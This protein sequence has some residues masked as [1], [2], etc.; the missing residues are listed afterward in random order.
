MQA[1]ATSTDGGYGTTRGTSVWQGPARW[2]LA[3][4]NYMDVVLSDGDG[5]GYGGEARQVDGEKCAHSG[6]GLYR[7]PMLERGVRNRRV[8]IQWGPA[9][10][11][12][13]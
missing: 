8:L 13:I 3:R 5:A 10:C 9:R 12:T 7:C 2:I 11:V 1:E 4:S 6:T